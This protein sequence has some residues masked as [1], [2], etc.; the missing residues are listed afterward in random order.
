MDH[1]HKF[2]TE[3]KKIEGETV[4]QFQNRLAQEFGNGYLRASISI[5]KTRVFVSFL[6]T[7]HSNLEKEI[8]DFVQTP[9]DKIFITAAQQP[10]LTLLFT[11]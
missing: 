2:I 1:V 5:E 11:D 8:K 9:Y 4:Q 3:S 7:T 6:K 10:P